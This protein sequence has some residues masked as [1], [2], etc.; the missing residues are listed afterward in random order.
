[1][2]GLTGANKQSWVLL[3]A[4]WVAFGFFGSSFFQLGLFEF[5]P[6]AFFWLAR[7]EGVGCAVGQSRALLGVSG[8]IGLSPILVLGGVCGGSRLTV[9]AFF[10]RPDDYG[11]L[12][13]D[14]VLVQYM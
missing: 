12:S 13:R 11:S 1:V 3:A 2:G 8:C 10:L 7:S 14:G 6:L 4:F 5:G 9:L